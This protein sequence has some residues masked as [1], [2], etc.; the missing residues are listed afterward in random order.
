MSPFAAPSRRARGSRRAPAPAAR[1]AGRTA[2]GCAPRFGSA[3]AR[4]AATIVPI[5]CATTC[6]R[7]DPGARPSPRS[8]VSHEQRNRQRTFDAV[9]SAPI[10]AGRSARACGART[11]PAAA[12]R[13]WRCRRGRGSSAPARPRPSISTAM[14]STKVVAI[15]APGS[16]ARRC[17]SISTFTRSPRLRN[18]GDEADAHARGR[19]GGDD[20][21]RAQRDPRG[22]GLDQPRDVEDEVARADVLAQL[23][24]HEAA[25]ARVRGVHLVGA[26]Q[27]GPHRA[28]AVERLADQPLAGASSAGRA[29]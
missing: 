27:P 1:A 11:P 22:D 10:R 5:E 21:A 12:S 23:A 8:V 7:S 24:V 14:R 18:L 6:A 16:R 25:H 9:R 29:R 13:C 4:C 2:R 15:S 3:A 20:V 26:H 28:E 17:L 19:A